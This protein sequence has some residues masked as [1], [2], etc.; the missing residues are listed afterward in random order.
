M[1]LGGLGRRAQLVAVAL[2]GVLVVLIS[3]GP[4]VNSRA[5]AATISFK[6][7]NAREITSGTVNSVAFTSANQ[8][9]NLIVVYAVWGNTG[10]VTVRDSRGNAYVSAQAA[11]TWGSGN[12]SRAQVF[13]AKNVAAGANTVTATFSSS[14]SGSFGIVYIHEYAGIDKVNPL[15]VSKSAKGSG[16]ALNSGS[17]TTTNANDLIFGAGAVAGTISS[18]G[19]GFATRFHRHTPVRS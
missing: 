10:S 2:A 8:S 13:Y 16:T 18:A 6:Q 4:L 7:V 1:R 5:Q 14:V 12:T 15:D 11:T 19:A 9:G 3:G 17:A